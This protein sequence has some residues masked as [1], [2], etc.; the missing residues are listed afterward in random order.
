MVPASDQPWVLEALARIGV[1]PYLT[2]ERGTLVFKIG[3]ED[4][5]FAARLLGE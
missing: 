3:I 1:I 2:D 5:V 4:G